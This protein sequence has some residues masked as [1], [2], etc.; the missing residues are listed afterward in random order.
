LAPEALAYSDV[1]RGDKTTS[2]QTLLEY[3]ADRFT[4]PSASPSRTF[5]QARLF[6]EWYRRKRN[7]RYAVPLLTDDQPSAPEYFGKTTKE[8]LPAR[9]IEEMKQI[10]SENS[11]EWAKQFDA[12]YANVTDPVT[13]RTTRI[14]CPVRAVALYL[15]LWVPLRAIQVRLLDSGEFD[16]HTY[17]HE[18][19][20]FIPNPNG[21]KGRRLGVFR[22]FPD[23]RGPDGR[24]VGLFINT[25][26]TMRLFTGGDRQG[27][28]IQWERPEIL[29]AL[30]L[31]R[32]WQQT[33]NPIPSPVHVNSL[34]DHTLHAP[35]EIAAALAGYAFL[36]RDAASLRASPWEPISY[37]RLNA[38]FI[39]LCAEAE[40][41]LASDGVPI[42]LIDKWKT[43]ADGSIVPKSA[44]V[45]LHSLR[46]SG[47]T[48]FTE[49]GCPI[50]IV[51]EFL[52][53]H[54][55]ILMNLWYQ[56][57]GFSSISNI[58]D[59]A[60]SAALSN[61]GLKQ[62]QQWIDE[63]AENSFADFAN[64]SL[65]HEFNSELELPMLGGALIG[66][67]VDGLQALRQHSV[68]IWHVGID[69]LC[70]N[71][72]TGCHEGGPRIGT[73]GWTRATPVPG[74]NG[75]CPEC[76]F[77]ITGPQ[78]IFGQIVKA[79][80]LLFHIRELGTSLE[81][82][83]DELDD[84][85]HAEHLDSANNNRENE[86]RTSI[87]IYECQ[88]QNA[89]NT[90]I[91]RYQYAERSI[92]LLRNSDPESG[93]AHRLIT[94]ID[95]TNVSNEER[96]V[97]EDNFLDKSESSKKTSPKLSLMECHPFELTEFAVQACEFVSEVNVP[98][99]ALRKSKLLDMMLDREGRSPLFFK[100]SEQDALQAG[101]ALTRFLSDLVGE[102]G[103]SELLSGESTLASL[104]LTHDLD[105]ALQA[106]L[107]TTVRP[108]RRGRALAGSMQSLPREIA[109][110]TA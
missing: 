64:H 95:N 20:S 27:F 16:E 2:S 71:G 55:T 41:R 48:N 96:A 22:E 26:K 33:Y 62:L 4:P 93:G 70:P 86:L 106:A 34:Q 91:R 11:F 12:D 29:Q 84:L 98:S 31:V 53:G 42:R 58:I 32:D 78:F 90:W 82:V 6:L 37:Q 40:R 68:G 67:S 28:N 83:Q 50:N 104:G 52:A 9:I 74:G 54:S 89:L 57:F 75:N 88:I 21:E 1:V 76:R 85:Q 14:W 44:C 51:T 81:S 5:G 43:K 99:A 105:T 102:R 19:R 109:T 10:L 60:S 7:K 17:S 39:E 13:R 15:M 100:L 47:I 87:D 94:D 103:V 49:F 77:W 101:N 30:T 3:L 36:F 79:N 56:K 72:R 8:A 65:D 46:V 107:P 92:A 80:V 61:A 45:T 18:E 35:S 63:K 38:L 24:F 23:P 66:G 110:E 59:R 108:T 73:K 69:G 25:N 97:Q